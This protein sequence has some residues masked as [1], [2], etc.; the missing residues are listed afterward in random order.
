MT[1]FPLTP[2]IPVRFDGFICG[3]D[4]AGRGCLA[5]PLFA[6]AVILD[7]TDPVSFLD[8]SKK[9]TPNRREHIADEI[10]QKA[11]GFGIGIASVREIDERGIEW[12]NRI[13]FTRAVRDLFKRNQ[14]DIHKDNLLVCIDGT[15]SALRLGLSQLTIPGGD[16]IVPEISAASILA[17]TSRDR[18]VLENLHRRF[19]HF[20]FD[21]HKGYATKHHVTALRQ[22]GP[23]PFHR[24]SFK[25]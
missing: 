6:A 4:E 5:G 10:R 3:I 21:S 24:Q 25:Y 19:P 22:W 20:G 7:K 13:A 8:D 1:A 12:A 14:V 2:F 9:L 18:W 11:L 17:K 15:R 23:T 16:G